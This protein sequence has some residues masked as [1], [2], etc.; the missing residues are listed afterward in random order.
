MSDVCIDGLTCS[1]MIDSE[2]MVDAR[3]SSPPFEGSIR[4]LSR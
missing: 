2:Q 1:T 4:V 3:Q